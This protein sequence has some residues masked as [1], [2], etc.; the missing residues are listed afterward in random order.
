MPTPIEEKYRRVCNQLATAL[1]E[2]EEAQREIAYLK[3]QKVKTEWHIFRAASRLE[4]AIEEFSRPL[5]PPPPQE[6]E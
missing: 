2:L 5:P 3:N 6:G 1:L 4:E